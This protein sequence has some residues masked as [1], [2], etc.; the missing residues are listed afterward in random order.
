MQSLNNLGVVHTAQ[1]K[2]QE[3]LALLTA[4]ITA[5]P[6]Y[7]E[8]RRLCFLV[9]SHVS[10]GKALRLSCAESRSLCMQE[11]NVNTTV[12][13]YCACLIAAHLAVCLRSARKSNVSR[14]S[15]TC[16]THHAAGGPQLI[17]SQDTGAVE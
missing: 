11:L 5:S 15:I 8:V 6:T 2:A 7:A 17:I 14:H 10:A 1:G 9:Y 4:A 3:A 12:Q 16:I 13:E